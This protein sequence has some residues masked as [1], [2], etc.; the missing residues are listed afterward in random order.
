MSKL[1][2]ITEAN[3]EKEVLKS[4]ITVLVD[5]SATWCGPCRKMIPVLEQLVNTNKNVKVV[6]IDIDD[7]PNL[8]SKYGV[9]SVPNFL[10]FKNGLKVNSKIGMTTLAGLNDLIK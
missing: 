2:E 5:F 4:E 1:L 6:S 7:C 9:K 3:F 8:A 10:V